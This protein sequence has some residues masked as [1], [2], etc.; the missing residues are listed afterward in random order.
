GGGD[1]GRGGRGRRG[2]GGG[3]EDRLLVEIQVRLD[4]R[5][6]LVAGPAELAHG[7]TQAAAEIG[8]LVRA[9]DEERDH[10]Q[11]EELLNSDVEHG[12]YAESYTM[13]PCGARPFFRGFRAGAGARAGSG[14]GETGD[15]PIRAATAFSRV[16]GTNG[17]E[18]RASTFRLPRSALS[19]PVA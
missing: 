2:R 11:D 9:E 7:P 5:P 8:Q 17:L 4:G 13:G 14:G 6:E 12:R 3:R 18:T 15:Q 1:V 16:L 19:A 10:H